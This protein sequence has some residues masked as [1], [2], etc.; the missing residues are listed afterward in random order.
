MGVHV[1]G[2]GLV[3]AALFR[4]GFGGVKRI[5]PEVGVI[6]GVGGGLP[7]GFRGQAHLLGFINFALL[8]QCR[9]QP[10]AIGFRLIPTD[11]DHWLVGAIEVRV[12][13]VARPTPFLFLPIVPA[14]FA[15]LLGIVIAAGIDKAG[16]LFVGH[17]VAPDF[18]GPSG[19][20]DKVIQPR[21]IFVQPQASWISDAAGQ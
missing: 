16:V 1:N 9:R 18:E 14:F 2:G 12:V 8:A 4:V 10:G 3:Q 11:A 19:G 7:F 13:P 17:R 6:G 5:T 20:A 21:R 15:P